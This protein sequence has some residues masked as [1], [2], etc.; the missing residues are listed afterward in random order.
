MW[1]ICLTDMETECRYMWLWGDL[2]ETDFS[3]LWIRKK[4]L[5][6]SQFFKAILAPTYAKPC[7]GHWRSRDDSDTAIPG[8]AVNEGWTAGDRMKL[9]VNMAGVWK[10][11]AREEAWVEDNVRGLQCCDKYFGTFFSPACRAITPWR[12]TFLGDIEQGND[13]IKFFFAQSLWSHVWPWWGGEVD[14]W[15]H[16]YQLGGHWNNQKDGKSRAVAVE[17]WRRGHTGELFLLSVLSA[18]E[19]TAQRKWGSEMY[20][21]NRN[22]SS[23]CGR[24]E[25]C[26][27]KWRRK[28]MW[29]WVLSLRSPLHHPEI[30]TDHWNLRFGSGQE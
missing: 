5:P 22:A 24:Q 19:L 4:K 21:G 10:S 29:P 16:E 18:W 20:T 26:G 17:T 6:T 2:L 3:V 13:M 15:K 27:E 30:I 12:F 14:R 7:A 11:V 8:K 23:Q 9:R 25:I 28:W 1:N